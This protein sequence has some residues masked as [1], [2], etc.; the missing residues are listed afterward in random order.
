MSG[1]SILCYGES[2]LV[3]KRVRRALLPPDL[4]KYTFLAVCD[5]IPIVDEKSVKL[6]VT[7]LERKS[8]KKVSFSILAILLASHSE[9]SL[10]LTYHFLLLQ[11]IF[12]QNYSKRSVEAG[13]VYPFTVNHK[14]RAVNDELKVSLIELETT[15]NKWNAVRAYCAMRLLSPILG[16]SIYGCYVQKINKTRIA[17]DPF[18]PAANKPYVIDIAFNPKGAIIR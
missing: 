18:S 10:L 7:L 12:V 17:V 2:G 13:K 5:G 14:V 4:P 3:P 15:K 9:M 6:G 1:I 11:L 8:T 16:D